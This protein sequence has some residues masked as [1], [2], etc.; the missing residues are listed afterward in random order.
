[1]PYVAGTLLDIDS[2]K[3]CP[4]SVR[5]ILNDWPKISGQRQAVVVLS[6]GTPANRQTY[7]RY[8]CCSLEGEFWFSFHTDQYKKFIY[9]GLTTIGSVGEP[10]WN[11][12]L[13]AYKA[14][15]HPLGPCTEPLVPMTA[16][17]GAWYSQRFVSAA[18]GSK[19]FV[20]HL[21]L[22]IGSEL[23]ICS[24]HPTYLPCFLKG[25]MR[26]YDHARFP[27]PAK[28]LPQECQHRTIYS[29]SQHDRNQ[30]NKQFQQGE[31]FIA[32]SKDWEELLQRVQNITINYGA[33]LQITN[34]N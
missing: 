19:K 5:Q 30:L 23:V 26:R 13:V 27:C 12:M 29:P 28:K 6:F 4:E 34:V 20:D 17:T 33:Q 21:A 10:E 3:C 31:I 7:Q 8:V 18:N 11:A 9:P 25:E 22:S 16:G 24:L 15:F 14:R 32:D 2:T 1:M